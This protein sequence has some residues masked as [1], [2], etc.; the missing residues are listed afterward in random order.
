MR[1]GLVKRE[2][3][4]IQQWKDIDLYGQMQE[5]NAAS[6]EEFLLHDGPPFTNGDVHIGTALNKILKDT[7]VRFQS[8]KGRQSPYIPGWDCHGLPIEHKVARQMK[9]EGRELSPVEMRKACEEFSKSFIE[10]QRGQFERL[11][12][13]ADWAHEYRTMN[14]SYEAEILRTFA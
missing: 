4:R 1:A 5:S 12:V 7:I 8:M 10:K 11:G 14:P 6:D 13:Q 9:D 2:P 3:E